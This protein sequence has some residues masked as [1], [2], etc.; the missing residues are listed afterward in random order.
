VFSSS[1]ISYYVV[2]LGCSKNQV[3]SEK[4]NGEM[5]TSGFK[6]AESAENADIIIINTCGFIQSAKEEAIKE[7]FEAVSI[8]ESKSLDSGS[9]APK[10]VAIGCLTQRYFNE[11]EKE[12]PELDYIAGIPNDK[13]VIELAKKFDINLESKPNR[14]QTPIIG[15]LYYSYIKISEGCSNNCSYCAIP[16]IRGPYCAFSPKKILFD[17]STALNRGSQEIVLIAQD[18]ALYSYEGD[19][20]K[21]L[22]DIM[23]VA[24][25]DCLKD[26]L[27]NKIDISDLVYIISSIEKVKWIRL[28]YCHPDHIDDK[29]IDTI[30]FNDKV[31]KYLDIPFQHSSEKVLS[32]MG[33]KGN[34][35][36]Y[37]SLVQKIRE[38]INGVSIRSTFMVGYPNESEDDFKNLI[39]FIKS[40]Q[41]DKVGAFIYSPEEGTKAFEMKSK[42]DSKT[43]K[44][45]YSKLMKVQLKIS[46]KCLEYKIGTR[47]N[48]L[49]EGRIDDYTCFGRTS[50]DAPEVDGLI[51]YKKKKDL[52][53]DLIGKIIEVK[54]TGSSEYDLIGEVV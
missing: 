23:S 47:I 2:S 39:N 6:E 14:T 5:L 4:L 26:K 28:L 33:R 44:N 12:I 22:S 40:A 49:I 19:M 48:I 27:K 54:I 37:L 36:K 53:E 34:Y 20:N 1:D 15:N 25:L 9:F 43:S 30:A 18:T 3:D 29:L 13:L 31:V 32:S 17:V 51:Y 52:K 11:I 7:I 35:E 24:G 10:I 21:E 42:V 38:K 45:R 50:Q 41:L 8:K 16:M 46:Q